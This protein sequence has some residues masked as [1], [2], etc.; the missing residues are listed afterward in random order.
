MVTKP[1][2]AD[3]TLRSVCY[4]GHVIVTPWVVG[5]RRTMPAKCQQADEHRGRV[6]SY[7]T[8]HALERLPRHERKVA[9]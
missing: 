5:R 2:P 6:M 1:H 8:A 4:D 9:A 3:L 7:L